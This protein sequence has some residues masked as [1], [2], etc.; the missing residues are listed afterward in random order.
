VSEF[1]LTD[2]PKGIGDA[3]VL[4]EEFKPP[5]PDLRERKDFRRFH[6]FVL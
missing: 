2:E 1:I 6:K 3:E 4:A 5:F